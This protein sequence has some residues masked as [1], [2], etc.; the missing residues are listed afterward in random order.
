MSLIN[1]ALKGI[2][3]LIPSGVI[4][5]DDGFEDEANK[6]MDKVNKVLNNYTFNGKT[7]EKYLPKKEDLEKF[8]GNKKMKSSKKENILELLS[9]MHKHSKEENRTYQFCIRKCNDISCCPPKRASKYWNL[10]QGFNGFILSP[11][12][13]EDGHYLRYSERLAD[14]V[15]KLNEGKPSRKINSY[16]KCKRLLHSA[17]DAK[18]HYLCLYSKQKEVEKMEI[19]TLPKERNSYSTNKTSIEGR[20]QF[21]LFS[22]IGQRFQLLSRKAKN[23]RKLISPMLESP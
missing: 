9:K 13:G 1:Y 14:K 5:E 8:F 22:Q 15:V 17:V 4:H 19:F 23:K 11:V 3:D 6:A 20:S 18:M 16:T 12:L 7:L 10:L 21:H 2:T